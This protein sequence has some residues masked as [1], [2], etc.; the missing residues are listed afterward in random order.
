VVIIHQTTGNA[1][2]IRRP[3]HRFKVVERYLHLADNLEVPEYVSRLVV[4]KD[5]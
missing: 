5:F 3:K 4:A 2:E 1:L